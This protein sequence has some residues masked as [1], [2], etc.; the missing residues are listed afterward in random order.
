MRRAT[1][2]KRAL[3]EQLVAGAL[4][5]APTREL[6]DISN[7]RANRGWLAEDVVSDDPRGAR[8]RRD[9]GGEHP[10]TGRLARSVRA[11][12]GDERAGLDLE[13][14][15]GDRLDGL[16]LDGEPLGQA[17]CLDD[18]LS[19]HIQRLEANADIFCPR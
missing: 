16:L 13:G 1:F 3:A 4:R 15:I 5:E 17:V 6:P 9:E 11:E 8:A 2:R 14:E 10:E 12:E 18:R 19:W 7:A